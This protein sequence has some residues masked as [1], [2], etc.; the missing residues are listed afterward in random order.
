MYVTVFIATLHYMQLCFDKCISQGER[1]ACATSCLFV[2]VYLCFA[3]VVLFCFV[4][5]YPA[6]QAA[7]CLLRRICFH[8]LRADAVIYI[9]VN[10][11][12]TV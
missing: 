3:I 8:F 1:I 4:L 11:T 2:F 9:V 10:Q 12:E 7:T 6:T 5:N